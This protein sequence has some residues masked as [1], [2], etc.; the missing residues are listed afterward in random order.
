MRVLYDI[1]LQAYRLLILIASIR[2]RKARAWL[3]GRKDVMAH[4]AARME[5]APRNGIWMHCASVGEFEQGRPVLEAIRSQWPD[6]HITLTFFSPSGFELRKDY[7]GAD[8]VTYLP[9]DTG[10]NAQQFIRL[11]RPRLVFFVKYEH[12]HHYLHELEQKQIPAFLISAIFRPEQPFFRP[13][14]GFWRR[15]L[16]TYD[17]IHVQDARSAELLQKIGLSENIRRSGDTRFDRVCSVADN[18]GGLT[19]LEFLKDDEKV[20]VAGST[21]PADERI[22]AAYA[23]TH[24][25]TR[26]IIAPHEISEDRLAEITRIFPGVLKWSAMNADNAASWKTLVIDNIGMLSRLYRYARV[27]YVGGGFH[28][29]GIHNVLEAAVYGKPVLFGPRNH[30]AKEASDLVRIGG[31]FVIR[32]SSSLDKMLTELLTDRDKLKTAGAKAGE[33]VR[34]HSGA[35]DLVMQDIQAYLLSSS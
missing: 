1:S 5:G 19:P 10:K 31:A 8:L 16:S 30:K 34:T 3:A 13:W 4:I 7:P 24:S 35:T 2:S 28:Q 18:A 12:W 33:Y 20:V 15:M 32:D 27:A 25:D 14:G 17:R 29:A 21:W 26:F 22:I 23:H 9:L 6:I 11:I